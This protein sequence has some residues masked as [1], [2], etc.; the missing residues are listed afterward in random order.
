MR[1]GNRSCG[2]ARGTCRAVP[3]PALALRAQA[4]AA[5]GILVTGSHIPF[6][7]NG[8]KYY[9]ASGEIL[10]HDEQGITRTEI[11]VPD[12]ARI[13]AAK[14]LPGVGGAASDAYRRRYLDFFMLECWPDI[15]SDCTSI[16][17]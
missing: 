2:A 15:E 8:I 10:K 11:M 1:H 17:R 5:P 13:G 6:D 3:T 12:P 9:M 16:V 14:F 7:R 4:T